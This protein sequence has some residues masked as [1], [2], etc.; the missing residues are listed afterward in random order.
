MPVKVAAVSS[1]TLELL[2]KNKELPDPPEVK[3]S[4]EVT[5]PTAVISPAPTPPVTD[6]QDKVPVPLV[7]KT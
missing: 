2:L 4:P 6:C 1:P 3:A 7:V 5:S